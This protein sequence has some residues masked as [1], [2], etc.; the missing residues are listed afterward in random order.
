M[1]WSMI[2]GPSR[3]QV[4]ILHKRRTDSGI[5]NLMDLM[6]RRTGT[7]FRD[8]AIRPLP[9]VSPMCRSYVCM[10]PFLA[11][12]QHCLERLGGRQPVIVTDFDE[13]SGGL[14]AVGDELL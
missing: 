11:G 10:P 1:T 12:L 14:A 13:R 6:S 5:Q 9:S 8:Q 7:K 2:E 3:D 4:Q